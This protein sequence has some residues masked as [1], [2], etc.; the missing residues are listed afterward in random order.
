MFSRLKGRRTYLL[1]AV[2]V[3]VGLGGLISGQ[4]PVDEA[5]RMIL[6]GLGMAAL[7]SGISQGPDP[8]QM[9]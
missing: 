1:A 6:E 7:R 3:L 8:L 4:I 5:T 9:A 2:S